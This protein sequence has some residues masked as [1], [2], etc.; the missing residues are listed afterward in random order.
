MDCILI[1]GKFVQRKRLLGLDRV[2]TKLAI[3][4]QCV[5]LITFL[6]S[7]ILKRGL[8]SLYFCLVYT[9]L[10]SFMILNNL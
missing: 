7:S 9:S 4:N 5:I 10:L 3:T 2:M 8:R 1:E 6:V